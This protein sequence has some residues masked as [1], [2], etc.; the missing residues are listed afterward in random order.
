VLD[1]ALQPQ[2]GRSVW[3]IRYA[4]GTSARADAGTGRILP[5]L[6]AAEA[7]DIVASTY[8]GSAAVQT[9]TLIEKDRVPVELRRPI[10]SWRIE[11]ADGTRFFVNADT[12][13]V[14]A[15]RTRLWRVYDFMWGLHIL[16]PGGREDSNHPTLIVL[17]A[18]SLI[19]VLMA[20]LLLP[21]RRRK[22]KP[23][24]D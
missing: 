15:R 4:D 12:G 9:V 5:Q 18:V 21:F 6:S 10:R 17:T 19:G 23:A 14:A 13:E 2:A 7:R 24:A 3:V 16:D 11:L 8:I 1:L 22:S 20:I